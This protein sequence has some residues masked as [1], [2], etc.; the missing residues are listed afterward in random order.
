MASA[1]TSKPRPPASH[2]AAPA[3]EPAELLRRAWAGKDAGR[4]GPDLDDLLRMASQP[5]F[6]GV[7]ALVPEAAVSRAV[8]SGG[9][10]LAH[11]DSRFAA[12]FPHVASRSDVRHLAARA[13]KTGSALG[14][15]EAADGAAVAAWAV[16]GEK[17]L[18]WARDPVAL[19]ALSRPGAVLILAFAPSRSDELSAAAGA[20][21]GLS[22]M[23]ARL[24]EAFLFAPTLEIAAEQVGIGRE[25]ARDAMQRVM[26]KTGAKRSR[27][28]VRRLTE[29]MSAVRDQAPLSPELL[30]DAFGLTRAE[31][32]VAVRL[33]AGDTQREAAQ[34]LGLQPQ[35]VRG[36]VKAALEKTGAARIKDLAR[37]A[38]EAQALSRFRDVAEPVFEGGAASARLSL[39]PREAGRH[40]AFL[41]YGPRSGRPAVIFH[42][43]LAGR[44]LPPAL[45]RALQARDL[46]P[47]VVQ[48]PGFGLTSPALGDFLDEAADDLAAVART[49]DLADISLFARDG[50]TA[51]ALAFA[52][53][54]P[55]AVRRAALL[56]PRSPQGLAAGQRSGPVARLS[57][58]MLAQPHAI[59][60][61]GE[62]IRRRTRTDVL[63]RMLRE[64]LRA[65]PQDLA[66]L[67]DPAVMAQLA[68]DIQA[69]FAHSSAGYAAEHGLYAAGWSPP[70]VEGG[71]PWTIIHATGLSRPPPREP[72]LALPGARFAELDGAGV[73]AQFT[74]TEALADLIAF[75]K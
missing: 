49:L 45:A 64:T 75:G 16:T 10:H 46:R 20:A 21:F 31:A 26:K 70:A 68:R 56:N 9:D 11:P 54:N 2:R 28:V 63:E 66:A 57:R 34:A 53:A 73:L 12:D 47:I 59:G 43:F 72:W 40:V 39:R 22:A 3:A 27:E 5:D 41:D 7:A 51:A 33:V 29:L 37:I 71:G 58:V 32:A 8:L 24:A 38:A 48:R 55:Q 6:E 67:D 52:S 44:S 25:T 62:F 17:A 35:T 23:E 30:T 13:R 69:Q 19:R 1:R 15:L 74:H 60:A 14:L 50:G 18:A 4:P 36:Y 61:F 42:G 65:L